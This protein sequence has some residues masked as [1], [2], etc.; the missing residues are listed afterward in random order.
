MVNENIFSKRLKRMINSK[1][2][3]IVDLA[4]KLDV[5]T[6][7]IYLFLSGER[8]PRKNILQKIARELNVSVDYLLGFIDEPKEIE[9]DQNEE[10]TQEEIKF[11][12]RAYKEMDENERQIILDLVKNIKKRHDDNSGE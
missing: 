9:I 10:T 8:F 3:K 7:A 1:G 11:I 12:R 6:Q 2:V 4:E 5:S